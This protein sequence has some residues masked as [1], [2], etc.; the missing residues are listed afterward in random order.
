MTRSVRYLQDL[1]TGLWF[2]GAWPIDAWI[3]AVRV[4]H[5]PSP[6]LQDGRL[7]GATILRRPSGA[8]ATAG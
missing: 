6:D 3:P 4:V 5:D 2:H 8:A 1:Q 7:T